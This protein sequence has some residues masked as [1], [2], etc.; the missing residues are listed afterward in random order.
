MKNIFTNINWTRVLCLLS[1]GLV[2]LYFLAMLQRAY[3]SGGWDQVV[4]MTLLSALG[5]GIMSLFFKNQELKIQ[6][7]SMEHRHHSE[8]EWTRIEACEQGCGNCERGR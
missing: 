4:L 6:M 1:F 7:E 2:G 8:L 5:L 3:L